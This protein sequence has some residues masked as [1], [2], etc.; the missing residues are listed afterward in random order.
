G[1]PNYM[2]PEQAEGKTDLVDHRTDQFALGTMIYEMLSGRNPFDADTIPSIMYHVVH[3][4]PKPLHELVPE[5]SPAFGMAV[6]R[7]MSKDPLDRL[8]GIRE[9]VRGL[10]GLPASVDT[11]PVRIDRGQTPVVDKVATAN[12]VATAGLTPIPASYE[13]ADRDDSRSNVVPFRSAAQS[14]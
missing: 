2:S 7:A 12:T 1:T 3:T 6:M 9:F 14:A 5:V 10:R 13:V 11:G 8:P 4:H